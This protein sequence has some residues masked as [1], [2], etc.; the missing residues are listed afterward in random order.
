M[1]VNGISSGTLNVPQLNPA[2]STSQTA[3]VRADRDGDSDGGRVS[4]SSGAPARG[5]FAAAINQA[6][7]QIGV[8]GSAAPTASGAT[9]TTQ[10]PLQALGKFMHNLFAALQSQGG[11]QPA[12]AQGG[13]DSD[14]DNDG[15]AASGVSG[16]TGGGRQHGGGSLA[17]KLQ[18]LIQQLSASSGDTSSSAAS[19]TANPDSTL[20]ALQQ[21]FQNLVSAQGASGS[22]ATL[23]S[24]LQTLAQ[25]L[26]GASP[27]GNIVRTQA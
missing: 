6:L 17:S 27:A 7:S 24:F 9:S 26:P 12:A 21:S 3:S 15:G 5:S 10:D 11:S 25:D 1:S 16:A 4:G 23:G 22:Q 20:A 8:S 19:G 2:N 13:A 18:G 14:G